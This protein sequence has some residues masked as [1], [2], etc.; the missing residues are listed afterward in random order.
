M[1]I[2]SLKKSYNGINALNGINLTLNKGDFLTIFGPNGAG[3]TT[4]IRIIA[5]LLRPSSGNVKIF[6]YSIE[7]HP[8]EFRRS[9]GVISHQSFLYKNLSAE[10]NLKFYAALYGIPDSSKKVKELLEL[11]GLYERR[12]SPVSEFSRGM[13][14]RLSIARALINDPS[15]IL[16]DEPYSGLDQHAAALLSNQLIKL[17][18]RKRTIIMV[19]HNLMF[20]VQGATKVGILVKG[21][22][23]FLRDRDEI[24]DDGFDEIYFN[25]VSGG[26]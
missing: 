9:I 8:E 22:M 24:G 17:H 16:L 11:M 23:L 5:T 3:K 18:N 2:E 19:T 6:E 12:D 4:L 20:G 14:Q 15:L 7:E 26:I 13:Q 1:I 25:Y 21:R 10:E